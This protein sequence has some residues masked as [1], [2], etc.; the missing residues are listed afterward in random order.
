MPRTN[1]AP[2]DQAWVIDT[3]NKVT[4]Q[5]V[6]IVDRHPRPGH[7]SDIEY[8]VRY[9]CGRV[10]RVSQYLVFSTK[11]EAMAK[12]RSRVENRLNRDLA[13]AAKMQQWLDEHPADEAP[14]Q[15]HQ[16]TK[17]VTYET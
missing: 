7:D 16:S 11:E 15:E 13:H 1:L 4:I 6:S 14:V 17:G 3:T 5:L 12:L 2:G 10:Y 9:K 8:T